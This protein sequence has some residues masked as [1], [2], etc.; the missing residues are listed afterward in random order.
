MTNSLGRQPVALIDILAV[1]S[2]RKRFDD[3]GRL[4]AVHLERI[5]EV[6]PRNVVKETP[7]R[8]DVVGKL[9]TEE[10]I[11]AALS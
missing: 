3:P 5:V 6:S 2:T 11:E 9:A 1:P 4:A 8:P 7:I 10:V